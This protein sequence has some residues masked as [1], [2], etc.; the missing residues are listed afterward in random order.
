MKLHF[1]SSNSNK[2]KE[3]EAILGIPL[4]IAHL[5]IDEIQS[6][7]IEDVVTKKAQAAYEIIKQPLIVDD[8]T[9][10]V[11]VWNGF[12]GPFIKYLREA[13]GNELLL[14]MLKNETNRSVTAKAAIGYH[15]GEKVTVLIGEVK[16]TLTSE[17]RG[18]DG[19]GFDPI[20]IP[21][22]Y[23]KTFAELGT[24]EK[25]KLSH[26]YRGLMKLKNYVTNHVTANKDQK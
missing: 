20:F 15:D 5:E 1:V 24:E 2:V 7:E 6:L 3:A 23:D 25:N 22:G 13:G 19:W 8:V 4:E 10:E 12:P 17:E 9:F 14:R 26:R 18:E 21:E 11:D 16:G